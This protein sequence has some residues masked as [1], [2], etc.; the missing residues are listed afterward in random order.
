MGSFDV[1]NILQWM[2]DVTIGRKTLNPISSRIIGSNNDTQVD[3]F[4]TQSF[5]NTKVSRCD[6]LIQHK[7]Q[8]KERN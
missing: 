3:N 2:Q 1:K 8:N 5:Y 4:L 7:I 6:S